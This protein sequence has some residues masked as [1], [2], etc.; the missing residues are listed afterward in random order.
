MNDLTLPKFTAVVLALDLMLVGFWQSGT[1]PIVSPLS[2]AALIAAYPG[3]TFSATPQGAVA[4]RWP[5][6]SN[7]IVPE[8]RSMNLPLNIAIPTRSTEAVNYYDSVHRTRVFRARF[9]DEKIMPDTFVVHQGERVRLEVLAADN[10]YDL[11]QPD[12][13]LQV[14]VAPSTR[15][16]I[17][18]EANEVGTFLFYC[19]SCGGPKD[20]PRGYIVVAPK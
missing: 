20:G 18:F 8:T 10:T 4:T 1:S 6:L 17:P 19:S 5:L 14:P 13:H 15:Q 12:Y 3:V 11:T 2:N 16:L 7:V 9:E